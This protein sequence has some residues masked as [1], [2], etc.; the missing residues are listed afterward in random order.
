VSTMFR[1]RVKKSRHMPD[2][3]PVKRRESD[4]VPGTSMTRIPAESQ[5]VPD[6]RRKMF[7]TRIQQDQEVFSDFNFYPFE[8]SQFKNKRLN[9]QIHINK[10]NNSYNAKCVPIYTGIFIYIYIIFG[11]HTV[12]TV[13]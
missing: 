7:G 12:C 4:K 11:N 1:T 13:W 8:I 5:N 3:G 6:T 10:L 2:K 9:F